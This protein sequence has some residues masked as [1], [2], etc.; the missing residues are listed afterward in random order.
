MQKCCYIVVDV[1][2][3]FSHAAS[4]ASSNYF[5]PK[6]LGRNGQR[7]FILI[8]PLTL[9]LVCKFSTVQI[10][11]LVNLQRVKLYS[12]CLLQCRNGP[13][14]FIVQDMLD[15]NNSQHH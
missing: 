5:Q 7:Q 10:F 4:H 8:L 2:D 11:A 14:K 1:T 6:N 12:S 13:I 3:L 9:T 15:L